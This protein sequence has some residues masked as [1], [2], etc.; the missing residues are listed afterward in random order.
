VPAPTET[1]V[2]TIADSPAV[3]LFT[4]R[5]RAT[6]PTFALASDNVAAVVAICRRLDGLPLAI[7][8]AAAR[9][10][11]LPPR[12]LLNRLR[13]RLAVLTTGSTDLPERQQTLRATLDW[14][15]TLLPRSEQAAFRQLAVFAA[16]WTL[17][18]AEA[19]CRIDGAL[20][21][22]DVLLRLQASLVDRSLV[23]PLGQAGD[24]ARF[25][26][27]E[28]LREYALDRLAASGEEA[29]VRRRAAD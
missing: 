24:E 29:D 19:V 12:A 17:S 27:L 25:D 26:M 1:D 5:A 14:S 11:E 3:R 7:E 21:S 15:Y 28:T 18:A 4:D 16:G 13:R 23:R 2:L 22:T 8:L 10:L 20:P 6:S 9:I